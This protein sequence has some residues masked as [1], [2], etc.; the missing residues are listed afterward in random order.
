[1][2]PA[3]WPLHLQSLTSHNRGRLRKQP[4]LTQSH[5]IQQ[6]LTRIFARQ[7][8]ALLAGRRQVPHECLPRGRCAIDPKKSR[9]A[10]CSA[11]SRVRK[12]RR[13]SLPSTRAGSRKADREDIQRLPSGAM[14]PP[15]TTGRAHRGKAYCLQPL[16]CRGRWGHRSRRRLSAEDGRTIHS[17]V[18]W[19]RAVTLRYGD[20]D[21]VEADLG[22]DVKSR[23]AEQQQK[24]VALAKVAPDLG[25]QSAVALRMAKRADLRTL[26]RLIKEERAR[27]ALSG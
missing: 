25:K 11:T 10:S 9:P 23:Y 6:H 1:M 26:K 19:R 21:E 7:H 5:E 18:H 24:L 20:L 22:E 8:P 14:P 3:Q 2:S 27:V 15:G 13:N 17:L 4:A 16:H 12:S